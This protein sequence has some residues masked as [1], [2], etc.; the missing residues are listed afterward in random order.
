[1]HPLC[2]VGSLESMRLAALSERTVEVEGGADEG[3]VGE[4]LGEVAQRLAAGSDFLGVEPEVVR[5]AQH[6]LEDQPGFF[7]PA[8]SRQGLD[9]PERAQAERAFLS[10]KA[11]C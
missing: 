6:L 7:E 5:V 11:I 2:V 3:Q 9:E 1:M 10:H 8:S 4:G